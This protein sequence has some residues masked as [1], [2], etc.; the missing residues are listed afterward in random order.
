MCRNTPSVPRH[1]HKHSF[2]LLFATGDM[3]ITGTHCHQYTITCAHHIHQHSF[4]LLTTTV[5]TRAIYYWCTLTTAAASG[6]DNL[7]KWD[8]G[9]LYSFSRN[10]KH[11]IAGNHMIYTR[12]IYIHN[13]YDTKRDQRSSLNR[14]SRNLSE[15][16]GLGFLPIL[17][18]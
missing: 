17:S 1:V 16:Q 3:Y 12:Y 8:Q 11:F 18:Y 2:L 7:T 13:I 15:N 10:W 4:F 14:F 6:K 5:A 9:S